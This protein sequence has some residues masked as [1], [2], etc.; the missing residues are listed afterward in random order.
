MPARRLSL[1]ALLHHEPSQHSPRLDTPCRLSVALLPSFL[2]FNSEVIIMHVISYIFFFILHVSQI[3]HAMSLS[4]CCSLCP[5]F[6]YLILRWSSCRCVVFRS[7]FRYICVS[8]SPGVLEACRLV[9]YKHA[10]STQ[11]Q[12]EGLR[13][14]LGHAEVARRTPTPQYTIRTA[15]CCCKGGMQIYRYQLVSKQTSE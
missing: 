1:L 10:A 4:L 2:I 8:F 7:L 13:T 6:L 9:A 5:P 14:P 12:T 3:L 11:H 15:A